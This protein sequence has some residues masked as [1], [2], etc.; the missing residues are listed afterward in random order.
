[1]EQE[2]SYYKVPPDKIKATLKVLNNPARYKILLQLKNKP[3]SISELARAI[4]I[5]QPT[6]TTYVNQLEKVGLVFTR[7]QKTPNNYTRLCYTLYDGLSL[8]WCEEEIKRLETQYS[9]DMPVGHYSSIECGASSFLATQARIIADSKDVSLFYH[10]IRMDAEL[11]VIS[12]GT[13]KYLFPYNI[14][15]KYKILQLELSAEINVAF[16]NQEIPTKV[17]LSINNL[18]FGPLTLIP[19]KNMMENKHMPEWYPENLTTRGKL[20]TWRVDSN[21]VYINSE[22]FANFKLSDLNL[23]AMQT[24]EVAFY[25]GLSNQLNGGLVIFGKNFGVCNQ[26]IRLTIKYQLND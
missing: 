2:N 25:V 4:N 12:Q 18:N 11:L 1:M 14:P 5:T 8:N 17:M 19:D 6:V 23:T 15:E 22:S 10:P 20:F 7:M 16:T 13:V 21:K 9:L 3:M 26:D 24:I